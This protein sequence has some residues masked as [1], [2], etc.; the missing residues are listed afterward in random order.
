MHVTEISYR[1]Y[2]KPGKSMAYLQAKS[3]HPDHTPLGMIKGEFLRYLAKSSKYEFYL[4]DIR[5]LM[6]AF[7]NRGFRREVVV[8]TA[9]KIP[10]ASR[11]QY[12]H[13]AVASKSR[14]VPGGEVFFT[15][16]I[17]PAVQ[18]ARS[19]LEGWFPN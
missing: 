1:I 17:D 14:D 16:T 19:R 4:E 13:R 2:G 8:N 10:W 3:F 9:E 12:R 15:S 11:E 18:V 5:M 6:T 7:C